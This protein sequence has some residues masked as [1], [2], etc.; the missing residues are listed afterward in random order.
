MPPTYGDNAGAGCRHCRAAAP[1]R[2]RAGRPAIGRSSKLPPTAAATAKLH[3]CHGYSCRHSYGYASAAAAAM[4]HGWYPW[5]TVTVNR[6]YRHAA[7]AA[8][9]MDG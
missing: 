9:A 7:N 4:Q 5:L 2:R 3:S 6:P 1:R 8:A